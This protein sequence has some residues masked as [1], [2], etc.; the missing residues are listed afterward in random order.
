VNMCMYGM[1]MYLC[2]CAWYLSV[3]HVYIFVYVVCKYVSVCQ[4]YYVVCVCV[5]VW[6]GYICVV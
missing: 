1:C 3:C 5:C 6:G 4:V 2:M